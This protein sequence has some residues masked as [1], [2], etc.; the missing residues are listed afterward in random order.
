MIASLAIAP[1][2]QASEG[3]WQCVTFARSYSGIQ[4][5]GNAHTWWDQ[6]AGHYERTSTPEVGSVL[7]MKS[8]G[9]GGM[10]LGHVATVSQIV[11]DREILITHAN[12]TGKG[13]VEKNVR[14]IDVSSNGDWSEV[15]VWYAPIN[16]IGT[17]PYPAF[18][19]IRPS[20]SKDAVSNVTV[21]LNDQRQK[22]A[23]F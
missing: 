15:R 13:E 18:G 9:S 21:A 17:T 20:G 12:W 4:I 16:A 19:F 23:Q 7:V 3:K 22:T 10:R 5:R 1:Q 2:A 8:F 11:S 14:A 6:A